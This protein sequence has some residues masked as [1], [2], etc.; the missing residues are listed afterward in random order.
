MK[1]EQLLIENFF[2]S[3]D[4][5]SAEFMEG[6]KFPLALK[7]KITNFLKSS[8]NDE[9]SYCSF[10]VKNGQVEKFIL[11][12][13]AAD[14]GGNLIAISHFHFKDVPSKQ[15]LNKV[16]QSIM[17]FFPSL[18]SIVIGVSPSDKK[19]TRILKGNKFFIAANEFIGKTSDGIRYLEKTEKTSDVLIREMKFKRDIDSV[20]KIERRAHKEDG[21]SRIQSYSKKLQIEMKSHYQKMAKL[22][23][24][25]VA[26][27]N[28][29]VIGAVG[30]YPNGKLSLIAT[31]VVD[32]KSQGQGV[33][34]KLYLRALKD[35]EGRRST[36]YKGQTTTSNVLA[37]GKKMKR[38]IGTIYFRKDY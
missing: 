24:A 5:Y 34:K 27:K 3:M 25:F 1:I 7:K 31:I 18:N 11:A 17:D 15:E 36:F 33:S 16:I 4:Q 23:T 37:M 10:S 19:V 14:I 28:E 9:N 20:L 26:T 29:K 12:R 2:K 6:Y 8:F 21:S 38:K 32:P 13:S 22:G 35:L 30:S